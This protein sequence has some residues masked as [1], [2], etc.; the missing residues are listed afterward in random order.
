MVNKTFFAV[1]LAAVC[2]TASAQ[3]ADLSVAIAGAQVAYIDYDTV[4]EVRITN[5]GPDAARNVAV[6]FTWS[7]DGSF[8]VASPYAITCSKGTAG[9]TCWIPWIA[10]SASVTLS[11]HSRIVSTN[12]AAVSRI[13]AAVSSAYDPNANNDKATFD[14]Y[15]SYP[16]FITFSPSANITATLGQPFTYYVMADN[17]GELNLGPLKIEQNLPNGFEI[18]SARLAN[19]GEPCSVTRFQITCPPVAVPPRQWGPAVEIVARPTVAGSFTSSA[20]IAYAAE[21]SFSGVVRFTILPLP[22]HRAAGR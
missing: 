18:I 11:L 6:T 9:H 16:L 4:H 15:V 3:T 13:R 8:D 14:F 5:D 21:L 1:L 19:T 7:F 17:Y 2:A 12:S 10:S 20:Y 22:R